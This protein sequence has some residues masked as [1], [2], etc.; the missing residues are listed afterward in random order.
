MS[1]AGRSLSAILA[2]AW[3]A[4]TAM[5]QDV[6][7]I[8][9]EE[10]VTLDVLREVQISAEVPGKLV[11]VSPQEEGKFVREGDLM[12]RVNDDKIRQEVRQA[13]T[14]AEQ[15]TEIKFAQRSIDSAEQR[16]KVMREANMVTDDVF[17]DNEMRSIQLEVDKA[18]AQ[19]DKANDDQ[20]IYGI[21]A[22]VKKAE[23]AQYEAHAPF[24]GLVTKVHKFPAQNVRPGD[25]V[26]TLTDMSVLRAV[27][28]VNIVHRDAIFVDDEV[29]FLVNL[30]P[31][32]PGRQ[33]P[34]AERPETNRND[35]ESF[36]APGKGGPRPGA[37]GEPA[38]LPATGFAVTQEDR[39]Y[40]GK[41][42]FVD[43]K[44]EALTGG[45]YALKLH[46][47]LPN[48]QDRHGRYLLQA[49]LPLSA[50]VLAKPR[51]E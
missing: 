1:A 39:V 7:R 35:L 37:V 50:T 22:D 40:V 21:T 44:V 42:V 33:A 14:Q 13:V 43:T 3:F 12:L 26:L 10:N 15:T 32:R 19:L 49:G 17:N 41:I 2:V 20:V 48:P 34:V 25:P 29:E 8:A 28:K 23:L 46:V 4:S 6:K 47:D 51:P 24:D 5:G 36:F 31:Q 27:V 38:F 45:T 18:H 30:T 16:Q 9:A 11:V